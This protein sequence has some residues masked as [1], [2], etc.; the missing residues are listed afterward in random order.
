M[1]LQAGAVEG[2]A[3]QQGN[4]TERGAQRR[5]HN[6]P[7]R[8]DQQTISPPPDMHHTYRIPTKPDDRMGHE[9]ELRHAA[10][11]H[12]SVHAR[13]CVW[14]CLHERCVWVCM[15][16]RNDEGPRVG[17]RVAGEKEQSRPRP[18]GQSV[19]AI[20]ACGGLSKANCSQPTSPAETRASGPSAPA[21]ARAS[22][23]SSPGRRR[24]R[25]RGPRVRAM[26]ACGGLCGTGAYCNSWGQ[27]VRA[28][29]ARSLSC[30]ESEGL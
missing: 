1:R 8:T 19:R 27:N 9:Q 12:V 16:K 11:G 18:R 23:P 30:N 13:T 22:G 4:I 2:L 25:L 6:T 14:V 17:R 24:Q 21:T 10:C 3:T 5:M 20:S 26:F 29:V 7:S 15:H 28:V